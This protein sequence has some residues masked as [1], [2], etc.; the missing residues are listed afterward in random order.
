MFICLHGWLLKI[1][2]ADNKN[3]V[4]LRGA[5]FI[6]YCLLESANGKGNSIVVGNVK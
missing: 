6:E 2:L 5:A 4:G 1:L 3:T